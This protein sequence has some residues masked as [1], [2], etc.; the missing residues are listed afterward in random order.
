MHVFNNCFMHRLSRKLNLVFILSV[1]IIV[2]ILSLLISYNLF[3]KFNTERN[4]KGIILSKFLADYTKDFLQNATSLNY[5]MSL[6]S[7]IRDSVLNAEP[8]WYKRV[9]EYSDSYDVL[10]TF[11]DNSGLFLLTTMQKQYDFVDLF[12]VQ[13][14]KGN[15]VGRSFG[16][17]RQRAD[18][19]W[20]KTISE[21]V[22]HK[23][24][25]SP[26]YY[27]ATKYIP[28]ASIFHPIY[29]DDIFIGSIGLDLN[30]DRLQEFVESYM[31]SGNM[32]AIITDM[33][34]VIVANS[35]MKNIKYIY[36]LKNLTYS[37][38]DYT[39]S[40]NTEG[41]YFTKDITLD[42]AKE[43]GD[44]VSLATS[45]KKGFI[46][47]ITIDGEKKNLYYAPISLSGIG[48]N[49]GNYTV[50]LEYNRSSII[51]SKNILILS[52]FVFIFLVIGIFHLIFKKLLEKT[53]MTPLNILINSMNRMDL[54]NFTE[55]HLDTND[56][57]TLLADTYNNL[58]KNL[59]NTNKQL[60][61][62]LESLKKS[63]AGYKTFAEIGIA[64]STEKK[65]NDLFQLIIDKS[66]S[67]TGADAGT[68][69][70]YNEKKKQLDFVIIN[71]KSKGFYVGGK[72]RNPVVK[73]SIPLYINGMKNYSNIASFVA[74]EDKIVNIPDVYSSEDFNFQEVLDYDVQ[75]NY[76]SKSMLVIPMKNMD[77]ELVGVIELVNSREKESTEIIPFSQVNESL[78]VSLASQ[79]A[80]A[81]TN[82]NLNKEIKDLFNS[83]IKSITASVDEKSPFTAGHVK[84]V[85]LL[86]MMIAE[87]I[88]RS[89]LG[90]FA[91]IAFTKDELEELRI[92]AWMHDIGKISTSENLI[93]K[94]TKLQSFLDGM[95]IL[96]VRYKMILNHIEPVEDK[97]INIT[98]EDLIEELA[99]LHSC[100]K[101]G[102]FLSDERKER[103]TLIHEREYFLNGERHTF[104]TDNEFYNLS[105]PKGN[106]NKEE[107][108]SIEH[109]A[110]ATRRILSELQ[111]PKNLSN[112]IDYASMHH[113]KL[114]GSGYPEG[115]TADQIPLQARII[116][117]A[118][119]FEALTAKD[120]PYREPMKVSQ[121]INILN[122]MV[123]N[124][125]ID[126]NIVQLLV[127]GD[128][129]YTY[130]KNELNE[131]Q[132][133]FV[134]T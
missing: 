98:S 42:W 102:E 96:D 122:S 112:V 127:D 125:Q 93:N 13:D 120:R 6:N 23:S 92:S 53:I 97:Q 110:A 45:G 79:A 21:D 12:F 8:N 59:K 18:R 15:Q 56:G 116:A 29:K 91:G 24:F 16:P 89:V 48:N 83:F 9:K 76:H 123:K 63:E 10:N 25:I 132:I 88:N 2:I 114:D 81:L 39:Q 40:L 113:E 71:V 65:T 38:L 41:Y 34:G 74:F 75:N 47:N 78:S 7:D 70:L 80:V 90:V 67:Q 82:I 128:I 77:N 130:A 57:F 52:V 26:V 126:R 108:K 124:G 118:D 50:L 85:V 35:N 73:P 119:I 17:L 69:Y 61:E 66:M 72:S 87:E 64:I 84:R 22:N 4:E 133:D 3:I 58:G 46:E 115:L 31:E 95:N 101:T 49:K 55:I 37:V 100:N 30:F 36:N 134:K 62:N 28:V 44:A 14:S 54:Q 131:E 33:N 129:I 60:R 68:L 5:Q 32:K 106:L 43:I 1:G 20:H 99:F 105:I 94:E 111:F 27:S 104:L 86:T 51:Y 109:H 11:S 103:L 121:A 107:R 19:W 117:V